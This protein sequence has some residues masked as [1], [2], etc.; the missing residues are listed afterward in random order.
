MLMDTSSLSPEDVRAA[1]EA[2]H[3]LGPEYSD[4]IVAAFLDRVDREISARVEQRLADNVARPVS[5]QPSRSSASKQWRR[6]LTQ[7]L[8]IGFGSATVPLLW[9]WSLGTRSLDQN[10]GRGLV[11]VT[12][13]IIAVAC[14]AHGLW[15]RAS[16]ESSARR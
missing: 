8:A 4:A 13:L 12:C 7:G 15:H 16:K 10:L 1:A 11:V 5:K 14:G 2:H 6:G 9:F 3:E